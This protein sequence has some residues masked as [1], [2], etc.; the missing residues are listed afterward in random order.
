VASLVIESVTALVFDEKALHSAIF[1]AC[2]LVLGATLTAG[3][4][5][6]SVPKN[7]VTWLKNGNGIRFG[8]HGTVLSSSSFDFPS[9]RGPSCTLVVWVR[10][11]RVWTTGT[12]LTFYRPVEKRQ[13][14]VEQDYADLVV[15]VIEAGQ[16]TSGELVVKN[17]FRKS[18]FLIAVTSDGRNTRI[19]IDGE[20]AAESRQLPLSLQAFSGQLILANS[21]FRD[22]SWQGDLKGLAIYTTA[23]NSEQVKR[24]YT[25]WRQFGKPT[26]SQ[27]QGIAALYLFDQHAGNT[28]PSAVSPG[29]DL[30]IPNRFEVVDHLRFESPITEFRSERYYVDDVIINILGFIPLGFICSAYFGTVLNV[31]RAQVFAI[32]IGI[33]T[34][35]AIEYFQSFLPT[36]Y[37]GWTDIFT[38][39]IGSASGA[40]L[41]WT[42]ARFLSLKRVAPS[43]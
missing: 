28:I 24:D 35:F 39:T 4:W 31:R 34:S 33:A 5:P 13:F 9:D 17:V 1:A 8:S 30:F 10:P 21:P 11:Q 37:S 42:M 14:V 18:D 7:D 15:R 32:M 3:L 6:F 12:L 40:L 19:Y 38:N 43:E 29:I 22:H 16:R 2:L 20:S 23:L 25:S 27:S 26:V 36:R 41:Y